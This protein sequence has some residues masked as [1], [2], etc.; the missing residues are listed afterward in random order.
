MS[1]LVVMGSFVVGLIAE[2]LLVI[3]LLLDEKLELV[4]VYNEMGDW[5]VYDTGESGIFS[6]EAV[7]V[8][9]LYSYGN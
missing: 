7:G 6:S 4:Y 8:G 3:Y 9:A 2:I 5:A 1:N